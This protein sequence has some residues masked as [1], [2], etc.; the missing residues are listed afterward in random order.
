MP[1]LLTAIITL[2][3]VPCLL[4]DPA[5]AAEVSEGTRPYCPSASYSLQTQNAL[6]EQAVNVPAR[7]VLHVLAEPLSRAIFRNSRDVLTLLRH[8]MTGALFVTTSFFLVLNMA[9]SHFT[10]PLLYIVTGCSVVS[11]AAGVLF[12]VVPPLYFVTKKIMDILRRRSQR[13]IFSP[14]SRAWKMGSL[15]LVVLNFFLGWMVYQDAANAA[16]VDKSLVK[17]HLEGSSGL[18]QHATPEEWMKDLH[19]LEHL[20]EAGPQDSWAMSHEDGVRAAQAILKPYMPFILDSA[21]VWDIPPDHLAALLLVNVAEKEYLDKYSLP[22]G[23]TMMNVHFHIPLFEKMDNWFTDH[24][25]YRDRIDRYHL[26]DYLTNFAASVIGGVDSTAG[27]M[28]LRGRSVV[29]W[30]R[31]NLRYQGMG[32]ERLT[33]LLLHDPQLAIDA[34]AERIRYGVDEWRRNPI[35]PEDASI[36]STYSETSSFLTVPHFTSPESA[37]QILLGLDVGNP[38]PYVHWRP[39]WGTSLLSASDFSGPGNGY[40]RTHPLSRIFDYAYYDEII[41]TL[42]PAERLAL[43]TGFFKTPATSFGRSG[44]PR[45]INQ[46]A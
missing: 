12:L 18:F 21:H 38:R 31:F 8:S 43:A 9:L 28:E 19:A 5:F 20:K 13:R 40:A 6:R 2:L 25:D 29:S 44:T 7:W 26:P 41:L 37:K 24:L 1:K 32:H 14:A 16:I 36:L 3:V 46:A 17:M 39:D 34:M 33:N 4:V 23:I 11:V 27:L 22:D 45:Q 42:G 15:A 10:R 30:Q 35:D